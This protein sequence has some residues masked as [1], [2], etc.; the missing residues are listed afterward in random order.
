MHM[1]S[2]SDLAVLRIMIKEYHD[3]AHAAMVQLYRFIA[4]CPSRFQFQ[5]LCPAGF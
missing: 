1:A 5:R 3:H 4:R 2:S